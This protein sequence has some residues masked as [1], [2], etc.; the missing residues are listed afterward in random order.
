MGGLVVGDLRRVE[1]ARGR[2]E[3]SWRVDHVCIG[4]GIGGWLWTCNGVAKLASALLEGPDSMITKLKVHKLY[5]PKKKIG[6]HSFLHFI[7]IPH[8]QVLIQINKPI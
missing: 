8:N 6:R 2:F 3:W 7:P 1:R 5:K 4:E